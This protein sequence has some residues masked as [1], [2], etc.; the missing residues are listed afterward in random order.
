LYA[1]RT[2]SKSY[3]LYTGF[4]QNLSATLSGMILEQLAADGL[5]LS[6]FEDGNLVFAGE[7][8][9]V[10]LW[11]KVIRE[12]LHPI[13]TA[14]CK[15]KIFI[16]FVHSCSLL[17]MTISL[18]KYIDILTKRSISIINQYLGENEHAAQYQRTTRPGCRRDA[19][20]GRKSTSRTEKSFC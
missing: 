12:R 18:N 19:R 7:A 10:N 3:H 5:V 15:Q 4:I 13:L 1:Y 9:A 6:V 8:N 11:L 14:I 16:L 17:F 20:H 2:P